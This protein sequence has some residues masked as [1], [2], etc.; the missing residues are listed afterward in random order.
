LEKVKNSELVLNFRFC[1]EAAWDSCSF[2][3]AW[4]LVLDFENRREKLVDDLLDSCRDTFENV[5]ATV[6]PQEF[7]CGLDVAFLPT[8][9]LKAYFS[10]K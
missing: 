6:S 2:P 7:L 4:R 3:K 5:Y 9:L 1:T 8:E 10:D